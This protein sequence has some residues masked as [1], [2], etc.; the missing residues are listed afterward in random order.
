MSGDKKMSKASSGGHQTSLKNEHKRRCALCEQ[1][2]PRNLALNVQD[3]IQK[4]AQR[5]TKVYSERQYTK[6][7]EEK[8]IALT[9]AQEGLRRD[10]DTLIENMG[11]IIQFTD[12]SKKIQ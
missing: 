6:Y 5:R 11:V 12:T 10:L 2:M 4:R 8:V 3:Q 9:I 1:V 7:L